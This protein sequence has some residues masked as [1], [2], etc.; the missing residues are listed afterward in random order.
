LVASPWDTTTVAWPGPAHPTLL[1]SAQDDR[2]AAGSFSLAL[3]PGS[4]DLV[5]Q[6]AQDPAS[7][8]GFA[9]ERTGD[10]LL[11]YVPGAAVFRVRYTHLVSG[12]AVLDSVDTRVTQDF[13]LHA[14]ISPPPTGADTSLVL[15]GL[16]KTALALHVPLDSIPAAVSIDEATLILNIVGIEVPDSGD[17]TDIVQVR[18]IRNV[19]SEGITEKGTLTIDDATSSSQ[20]LT[21]A[22]A[23]AGRR[24]ILRIPGALLREWAA[25]S[26]SNEG[27]YV[28]LTHPVNRTKKFQVGSRESSRPPE[29][30]VSYTHLPPVRF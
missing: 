21:S 10:G 29:L 15:G 18:R 23:G 26:S 11:A 5:K 13:Y 19:W 6:W 27:L 1:G 20:S 17:V 16:F 24:I 7:A 30:H 14:P 9:L 22:Y 2:P 28:S 3:T 4:F 12:N 8:P 25:T